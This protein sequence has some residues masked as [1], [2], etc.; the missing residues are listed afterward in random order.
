MAI[1]VVRENG[2]GYRQTLLL[3]R[4]GQG[5][6]VALKTASITVTTPCVR[7]QCLF[8][9]RHYP[10]NYHGFVGKLEEPKLIVHHDKLH[11]AS[12]KWMSLVKQ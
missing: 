9:V 6:E 12:Y 5:Q 1:G 4:L 7:G 8:N 11:V 3:R 10:M 2:W